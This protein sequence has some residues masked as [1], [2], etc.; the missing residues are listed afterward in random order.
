MITKCLYSNFEN[1]KSPE[2]M[3]RHYIDIHKVD[4]NNKLFIN[5]LKPSVNVFCGRKCF[6]CNDFLSTIHFKKVH[7]FLLHYGS[8]KSF[9]REKPTNYITIEEIH[10]FEINSSQH[11]REYDFYNSE[12]LVND[13]L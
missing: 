1:N 6:R 10:K 7:D 8:G 3:K 13:F 2:R 11:S 9:W 4:E 12:S 5:L